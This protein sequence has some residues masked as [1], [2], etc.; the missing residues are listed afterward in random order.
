M[1]TLSLL[2]IA[3]AVVG[4]DSSA[5]QVEKQDAQKP[6]KQPEG[7]AP[8][9]KDSAWAW[10]YFFAAADKASVEGLSGGRK[11]LLTLYRVDKVVAV[12]GEAGV[13]IKPGSTLVRVETA[14]RLPT[15]G[16]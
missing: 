10:G 8:M 13:S 2:A 14:A 7:G 11:Q 1:R 15:T 16:E 9:A 3:L 4:C 12:Q 5:A 6:G